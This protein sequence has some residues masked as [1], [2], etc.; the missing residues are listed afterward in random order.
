MAPRGSDLSGEI[1]PWPLHG[2]PWSAGEGGGQAGGRPR[3]GWLHPPAVCAGTPPRCRAF[4]RRTRADGEPG[5]RL[6]VLDTGSFPVSC[7]VRTGGENKS[8]FPW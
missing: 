1:Q 5:E 4:P 7:V 3:A 6:R 8:G 2:P